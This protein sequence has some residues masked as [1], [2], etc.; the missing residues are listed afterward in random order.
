MKYIKYVGLGI[1]FCLSFIVADFA[2]QTNVTDN[3]DV[4]T[5]NG[6]VISMSV[7][8]RLPR[9]PSSV[10]VISVHQF[11][12]DEE[13]D[14]A[15]CAGRCTNTS[16]KLADSSG[17]SRPQILPASWEVGNWYI[18]P[19][20]ASGCASDNNTGTTA[21]CGSAGS[22]VGPLQ[23]WGELS[24]GRW[25]CP[26]GATYCPRFIS[27][28][29]VEFISSQNSSSHDPVYMNGAAEQ[30][31]QVTLQGALGTTQLIGTGTIAH[32][33]AKNRA[34]PQ[35]LSIQVGSV[36]L[37]PGYLLVNATHSSRAWVYKSSGT[38]DGGTEWEISQPLTPEPVPYAY[39]D[40][41]VNTWANGDTVH[42]YQPALVNV[43]AFAINQTNIDV[44]TSE[45][46]GTI[47]QL[48]VYDPNGLVF[49]E[50]GD[51][52]EMGVVNMIECSSERTVIFS[53]TPSIYGDLIAN[54]DLIGGV[55]GAPVVGP[56]PILYVTQL[57]FNAGIIG[58]PNAPNDGKVST[59][60]LRAD[61]ILPTDFVDNFF[62][63]SGGYIGSVYVDTGESLII[64][65]STD[66]TTVDFQYA[67]AYTF[68][69]GPGTT[70]V[71]QNARVAYTASG[72][73]AAFKT[74]TLQMN[75]QTKACN[76]GP[77]TL[78]TTCNITISGANLDA[79]FG[80]SGFGGNAWVPGGSC[81]TDLGF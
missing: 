31:A 51:P 70:N 54:S 76:G 12:S 14:I 26:P 55:G 67:T 73:T 11:A 69:W 20:N 15:A 57:S 5:S 58:G 64:S 66:M 56:D 47:Y 42:V 41:E 36:A 23:T 21:T 32:L 80:A 19:A 37:Q 3:N 33:V 62:G 40:S 81:I 28:V 22:L 75:G 72:A 17:G 78:G 25:G 24:Q 74:A 6:Q 48:A 4:S 44:V 45:A 29:T 49:S 68:L 10:P 30:G 43:A 60:A 50:W 8:S 61:V 65:G 9:K 59:A 38:V 35:L 7:H 2:C 1:L 77:T 16:H 63:M 53:T 18:D 71:S 39:N 52:L 34:T 46:F 13:R 79:A 27:G